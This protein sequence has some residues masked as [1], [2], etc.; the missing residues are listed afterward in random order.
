MKMTIN[1]ALTKAVEAHKAGRVQEADRYY[2]AILKANPKHAD[3]NH[4]MGVIAAGLG[5]IDKAISYFQKAVET[6]P[7]VTQFWLSLTNTLIKLNDL[8]QAKAV[9]AKA[10]KNGVKGFAFDQLEQK[11]SSVHSK[12]LSTKVVREQ[13]HRQDNIL[14]NVNLDQAIKLAKRKSREGALNQAKEIYQDILHKFPQNNKAIRGL[15][16]LSG[17]LNASFIASQDPSEIQLRK[18]TNLYDQ[19]HLQLAL[20]QCEVL[21]YQYP[22]SPILLN[23]E[24]VLF[25][26]LGRLDES[27]KSYVKSLAIKPDF[28]DAHNNMG[29]VFD[30]QRN[31]EEAVKC[32]RKALSIRPNYAE[33][34][35]GLGNTL[36]GQ[37]K[38]VEAEEAYHK[39]LS[40]N[41]NYAEV[42]NNLGAALQDQ[43]KLINAEEAY[44]KAFSI[45]P[46]YAAAHNNLGVILQEQGKLEEAIEAF[47]K[48]LSHMPDYSEAWGNICIP[49]QIKKTKESEIIDV[50]VFQAINNR[51]DHVEIAKSILSY[52]LSSGQN[53]RSNFL[54]K[55]FETLSD[56]ET[57]TIK[58]PLYNQKSQQETDNVPE[59][60][61][62]LS[63]FGRSGSGLL[64]SLIDG[65][66]EVS[67]LPCIY[68]SEYFDHCNWNKIIAGGWE[69][70]IDN[71]ILKYDVLFDAKSSVPVETKSKKLIHNIGINFGMANLG[72]QKDEVL[73]VN[74]DVFRQELRRLTAFHEELDAFIFFK[75]VHKAYDIAVRDTEQKN[76]IFYHI[77]N[78]D[79]SAQLNFLRLANKPKWLLMVREPLQSC[80]SWVR[81]KFLKGDYFGTI[82]RILSML[83][84]VDNPIFEFSDAV[85]IRLEDLK[86]TP[87]KTLSALCSW[88][89]IAESNT[90]YEMTAQGKKWW[91]DPA[92]PDFAKD[93]MNPFGK[94]SVS[95]KVGSIFSEK[96][97][98]ILRT[99]FH[100]FRVHFGYIVDDS[101]QFKADL[102]KIK[103]MLEEMF[104]FEKALVR[105]IGADPEIFVK[106][107]SYAYFRACLKERWSTLNEF[108]TY[109][110]MIMPIKIN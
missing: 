43:G 80:E 10:K 51:S 55:V 107:G 68:F 75:L 96:D 36:K 61:V 105:E 15:K 48:A 11:L 59:T 67:T 18:I 46:N 95:R 100:P 92:S 78:P 99:L 91:G 14:D 26:A 5:K 49:L 47:S 104:D 33:A 81:L 102:M 65:H 4:N 74:K 79:I 76:I 69:E 87:K 73:S 71:F 3:A 32:Y 72:E 56:V 109:P 63:H 94:M 42:Y 85:G 41:P 103:P 58:N 29:N 2:T 60:M 110:K 108:H 97:Q 1:E 8:D 62:A 38:L 35:Y 66:P 54:N 17:Q 88:L 45:K 90:L 86:E 30:D 89:N 28:A 50:S 25:R 19:G 70:M 93:G 31:F 44:R 82:S 101:K 12:K 84:E 16:E 21:M 13:K 9:L 39:A 77:H 22:R 106:S 57:S 7:E 24:G 27:I 98:F 37:G 34:L 23:I 53:N 20:K 52:Q 40:I 64:H 83:Y 6:N